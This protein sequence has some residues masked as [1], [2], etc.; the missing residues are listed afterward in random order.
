LLPEF[1]DGIYLLEVGYGVD[2]PA[3]AAAMLANK[4]YFAT[5]NCVTSY[6]SFIANSF[7]ETT[8]SGTLTS[9]DIFEASETSSSV[10]MISANL[11]KK[12]AAAVSRMKSVSSDFQ[13][14]SI[15]ELLNDFRIAFER[16]K[17]LVINDSY[18]EAVNSFE[19][20]E[21]ILNH[22]NSIV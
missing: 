6:G 16:T 22:I 20:A 9:G 5:E 17:I 13:Q 11:Q 18:T 1:I 7:I 10:L 21:S 19:D 12:Y 3:P 14:Q 4:K 2:G 15:T 8:A